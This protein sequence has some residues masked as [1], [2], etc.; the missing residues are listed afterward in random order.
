MLGNMHLH[1]VVCS[2]LTLC[3]HSSSL[4]SQT[5][6]VFATHDSQLYFILDALQKMQIIQINWQAAVHT[7]G[8]NNCIW[9]RGQHV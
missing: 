5:G 1:E 6:E 2:Y 8:T 3:L 9:A 4:P 7:S